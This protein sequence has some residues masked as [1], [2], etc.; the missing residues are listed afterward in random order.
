MPPPGYDPSMPPP[1]YD[2]GGWNQGVPPGPEQPSGGTSKKTP[3]LV[4]GIV[5]VVLLGGGTAYLLTQGGG[6]GGGTSTSGATPA[7]TGSAQQAAAV[8]E[9]LK[10]GQAAR[11]HLPG[12]LRTCDD[13]SAGV[14]GFQR[15]VRDRQQELTKSKQLAVN[16]LPNGARLRKSMIAAYQSSLSADQAYLAWAQEIQSKGCGKK[17][18]PLTAHYKDAIT[19]NGKAGPAKRQVIALWKPTAS[20]QGLPTYAWNRL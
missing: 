10:S 14:P 7:P 18:A 6:K 2:Q 3:L 11:G 13:V 4:G 9:I 15:V 20:S 12:R 17:V 16:G 1:G 5:A 8:N 19:A